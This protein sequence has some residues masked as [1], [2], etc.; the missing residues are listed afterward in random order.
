MPQIYRRHSEYLP[1]P[2][3]EPRRRSTIAPRPQV[4]DADESIVL[5]DLVRTGEASRLRRRG[6]MRLDHGAPRPILNPPVLPVSPT[7]PPS[8]PILLVPTRPSTPPSFT[9]DPID[10]EDYSYNGLNWRE[11]QSDFPAASGATTMIAEEG[12]RDSEHDDPDEGYV[13]TC[14]GAIPDERDIRPFEPSILPVPPSKAASSSTSRPRTTNRTNGCGAV[15]HMRAFPQRP[16]SVWVGKEE[17]TEVVVGMDAAYFDRNVV[18]KMQRSAC[19]CIRE[20]VGCSVCGN[21]L[22]TRYLPCQAA[23]DGIFSRNNPSFRPSR[24]TCPSGRSYW[25]PRSA[26]R[27]R[28]TP[29]SSYSSSTRSSAGAFYV[30]TFFADH[31]TSS[32]L[33]NDMPATQDEPSLR[34][35]MIPPPLNSRPTSPWY[36]YT[37]TASPRPMSPYFAPA[38]QTSELPSVPPPLS[39]SIPPSNPLVTSNAR[40]ERIDGELG[41][42]LDADGVLVES[43]DLMEPGSPDK[44]P[45]EPFWLGR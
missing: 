25:Q 42:Q 28:P 44:A 37:R 8:R 15:V 9:A 21:T 27:N 14:G 18:A 10:N 29:G 39:L 32:P 23:S 24:P 13:L 20:G 1:R 33:C 22:G 3:L 7:S 35:D 30:Y 45:N 2:P 26:P 16:R 4:T 17:A 36:G 6:A 12:N 31:V 40:P 41:I 38:F 34:P 11:W 43:D 19:G 5:S